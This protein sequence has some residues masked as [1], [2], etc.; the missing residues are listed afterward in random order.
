VIIWIRGE[1]GAGKTTLAKE[2]CSKLPKAILLDGDEMRASISEELDFS[3]ED[4][5]ENN[6]R[7]GKLAAV[8]HKQGFDVI[9]ATICPPLKDLHEQLDYITHAK[10]INL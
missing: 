3:D 6:M 5:Y 2:L 10:V 9:V 1:R 8:L 4:R 7:I